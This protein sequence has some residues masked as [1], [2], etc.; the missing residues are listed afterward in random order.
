MKNLK[1]IALL[2]TLAFL[3]SACSDD[4]DDFTIVG[5]WDVQSMVTNLYI[6]GELFMTDDNEELE[7]ITFNEDGT[8]YATLDDG[9]EDAFEWT[10]IGDNLTIKLDEPEEDD[11]FEGT[12]VFQLTEKRPDRLEG[13][14]EAE[15][16]EEGDDGEEV[17]FTIEF[18]MVLVR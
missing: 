16:T 12:M 10:L 3:F 1:L 8:C 5:T 4:D 17:T 7:A 11:P 14:S 18:S 9:E 13:Y 6:D 15:Y 2:G